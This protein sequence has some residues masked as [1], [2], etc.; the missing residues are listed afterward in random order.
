M[1]NTQLQDLVIDLQSRFAFQEDNI[2]VLNDIVTRQQRQIDVLERELELHREKLT[3]LIQSAA[4][5]TPTPTAV[6]ERP[7]HY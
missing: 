4:E 3:E 5:R 6:D 7:P 2:Q 1:T